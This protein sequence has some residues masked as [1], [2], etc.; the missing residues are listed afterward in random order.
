MLETLRSHI[1]PYTELTFH[2]HSLRQYRS[3]MT[4]CRNRIGLFEL[5]GLFLAE[6]QKMTAWLVCPECVKVGRDCRKNCGLFTSYN[7]SAS[8]E[9][10]E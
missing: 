8:T 10:T 9:Y 7:K 2:A 4:V 1:L 6:A 5:R 3:T